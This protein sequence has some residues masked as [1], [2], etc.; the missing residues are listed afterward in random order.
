MDRSQQLGEKKISSL[1]VQFSVPA[2]VG[3]LANSLY[4]IIDRI[5]IGNSVG[6]LGLAGIT[7]SF[8]IML[9]IMAFILLIGIGANS[10]VSIKLGEGNKT[11]AEHIVGNALTMLVIVSIMIT[12]CGLIFLEPLM[13]IFG[14]SPEVLPYAK[15]YMQIIF[16]GVILQSIGFGMS[17]FIRGE[18]NPRTAMFTMLLG[19]VLNAIFCPIFIF[20][21][22][23]GIRG[24][25]LATILAQGISG[26]WVLRYFLLGKSSLKLR[27][28]HLKP[29]FWV[30]RKIASLG[31]AQFIQEMA[32]SLVNVILIWSLVKYGGDI[33]IS[34]MGIVTSLQSLIMMPLF[35]INQG[36]QPIVGYNYGAKKYDRVKQTLKLAVLSASIVAITGFSIIEV[37]PKQVVELFNHD[38]AQLREF[39]VYALRVFLLMMPVI[40]FQIVGSNYFM[41]V[42]KPNPAALLSL[43][44]QVILLIPAVLILPLFFKLHGVL[45]AGPLADF[46]AFVITGI[47]LYRELRRLDSKASLNLANQG[48]EFEPVKLN[49]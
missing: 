16:C 24:S 1:L 20:G 40:G 48:L 18:G 7:I 39:T 47:W 25:A 5:F 31:F 32:T 19:A 28:H 22:K 27:I 30:V 49:E 10:L 26:I 2:I 15:A 36:V 3:M 35:G 34:G 17:N 43:S 46:G 14:A 23:M 29:D 6:S 44:R 11:E 33:A 45:M 12:V 9:G 42:G 37:F 41:A 21:L 38:D 13:K 4:N 8:P